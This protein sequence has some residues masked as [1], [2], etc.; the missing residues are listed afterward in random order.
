MKK[1][2]FNTKAIHAGQHPDEQTGAVM[3]PVYF[4]STYAQFSPGK[5]RGYEYSRT[6]NPTRTALQDCVAALENAKYGLAFSSGLGAETTLMLMLQKGDHVVCSDDVYGGTF[7]LFDKIFT[8]FG[9]EYTFVDMTDL[10]KTESAFQKN[11]KMVWIETPTNPMLKLVDIEKLA[12]LAKKKKAVSVVDNT[13]MSPYF[14]KPI[15]LGA[16]VVLHSTT[17]FINGHSDVVGGMI[18]T[19]NDQI[20]EQL[21]FLQNAA[22][23]T[24]GPMDNFLTLR[25]I[26]TLHVRM[27]RHEENAK[28]IA[29]YLVKHKKIEKVIYPGLKTHPQ[30]ALA[31]KQMT[32]FGGMI[33]ILIKGDTKACRRFLENLSVFTLA[34]SLGGVE[35]LVNHPAIMTHASVPAETRKRLGIHDNLAR[36]SVGI[37]D[38]Q[39][40]IN[41]L[42]HALSFV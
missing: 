15:D 12:T 39:D 11:T 31:K 25:G 23:A 34:E 21:R 13:F 14:Q 22:G 20:H 6:H 2:K 18:V 40:L 33:T 3:T 26:K 1:I 24:P 16:D 30:Y 41:G 28:Q 32:G 37:E 29:E 10:K 35:S 7:R 4:T 19:S 5:H 27:Q 38:V 8:K 17:K 9:I 42:E 36:L